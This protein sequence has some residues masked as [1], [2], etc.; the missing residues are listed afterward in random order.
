MKRH[1]E[2]VDAANQKVTLDIRCELDR[3]SNDLPIDYDTLEPVENAGS[4][5]ISG[6][7]ANSAGQCYD[8]IVPTPTQKKLIDFWKK[9]HL[10]TLCA[11]TR[12][13][14]EVLDKIKP[15]LDAKKICGPDRWD[16]ETRY[17]R[18]IGLLEDRG[19]KFGSGWLFKPYPQDELDTIIRDIEKEEEERQRKLA[20]ETDLCVDDP[21][22]EDAIVQF[23]QDRMEDV[24]EYQTWRLLALARVC[25]LQVLEMLDI[26]IDDRCGYVVQGTDYYAGTDDELEDL[27]RE[28]LTDDPSLWIESVKAGSTTQGLDD[29]VDDVI[30]MDGW[31]N[32]LNSWDG[33]SEE[34]DFCEY[35]QD[36][37][38]VCRK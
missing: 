24:N 2:F 32:V 23:L 22:D 14:M 33:T 21:A 17:L 16:I 25:H 3:H 7:C 34:V 12:K 20:Y 27:A 19:Y 4:F 10:N 18:F 37:I 35:G 29:W 8:E 36:S 5:S 11:G 9:Y 1:I 6:E 13:Q 31:A 30:S 15:R 28:Y 26:K 38:W